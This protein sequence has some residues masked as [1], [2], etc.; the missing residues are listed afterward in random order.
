MAIL[1]TTLICT[2]F[3]SVTFLFYVH[4]KTTQSI[5]PQTDA[6][7]FYSSENRIFG[8][9]LKMVSRAEWHAQPPEH[10]LERL[11]LPSTRVII[12]HTVTQN[13]T[14]QV[15]FMVKLKCIFRIFIFSSHFFF[16]RRSVHI[17]FE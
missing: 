7:D 12:A 9:P 11:E 17:G 4:S 14:T 6:R 16:D 13:C 3:V 8:E 10:K 15:I 1:A 5:S 2:F